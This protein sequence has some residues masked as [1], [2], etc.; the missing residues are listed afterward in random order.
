MA[1]AVEIIAP[2]YEIRAFQEDLDTPLVAQGRDG[3]AVNR[4]TAAIGLEASTAG[5][6]EAPSGAG[7]HA[8]ARRPPRHTVPATRLSA[9]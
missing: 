4:R 1:S 8:S 3:N 9:F 7:P 6:G 2:S 5:N